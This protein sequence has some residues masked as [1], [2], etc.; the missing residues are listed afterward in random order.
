MHRAGAPGVTLVLGGT[1]SGKSAYAEDLLA[2]SLLAEASAPV[3]VATAQPIDNSMQARIELHR[4]R[5]GEHWQ[6]MEA[7]VELAPALALARNPGSAVLIDSLTVWLGNLMHHQKDI[8]S[9]TDGLVNHLAC[10][11]GRLVIV[12]SEVGL[13]II[14]AN[15][16]ARRFAD[17][18][19]TLNQRIAARAHTVIL[20]TAG[21][22]MA[23]K[24]SL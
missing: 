21:L 13:G 14:P 22:P 12:A 17:L 11:Q 7:A 8:A 19:G 16:A 5:R 10:V 15:A 6:T 1:R 3:Y 4:R 2:K 18:A 24:G 20:V 9:A 23:L